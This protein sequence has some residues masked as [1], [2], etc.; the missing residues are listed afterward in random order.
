MANAD[1]L[2]DGKLIK[3]S[4]RVSFLNVGTT[5]EPQFIRM[6]GFSSMS[7]SKSAKEYSRQYVDEDTE[8]SDVVGY[9]TQ[10]DRKSVV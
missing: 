7:E 10:I 1:K 8:R 5:D 4:K 6:Q 9:A 2:N 3:R